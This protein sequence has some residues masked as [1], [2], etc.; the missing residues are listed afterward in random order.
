MKI[1]EPNFQINQVINSFNIAR[2]ADVVFSEVVSSEHYENIISKKNT[3]IIRTEGDLVFYRTTNIELFENCVIFANTVNLKNL[4]FYLKRVKEY[5]NLKLITHQ[6]DIE[7]NKKL[8]NSKPA[9]ISEWYSP[10][11]SYEH[12]NLIPIPLGVANDYSIK[13]LTSR[14]FI[15]NKKNNKKTDKIYINF[16]TNTNEKKRLKLLNFFRN[17]SWASFDNP[18]LDLHIYKQKLES[19]KFVLCPPGNGIDTHRMWE[20]LYLDSIPV[21][22]KNISSKEYSNLPIIYY[23]NIED[24]NIDYLNK[25]CEELI[26]E[27]EML[28]VEW[29]AKKVRNSDD[30]NNRDR[31][32]IKNNKFVNMYFDTI[33][34]LQWMI[35]NKSIKLVKY[36]ILKLT[37]INFQ[38]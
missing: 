22:E 34:Y 15:T 17:K 7:I 24:V 1:N 11:I 21:V 32:L 2:V 25:Q 10:N 23:E 4:F 38:K 28:S 8:F 29:W 14:F 35:L 36:Y 12:P 27:S 20:T 31:V 26:F 30:N 18:N 33:N 6:T 16:V 19:H 13:N 37:K 9:C 3:E 5:K